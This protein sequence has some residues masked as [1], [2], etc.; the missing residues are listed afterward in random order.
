MGVWVVGAD[1]RVQI[2]GWRLAGASWAGG[3]VGL[4]GWMGGLVNLWTSKQ[5]HA[6]E[7]ARGGQLLVLKSLL[8]CMTR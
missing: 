5:G 1:W 8:S 3:W 6:R 7:L 2:G 4:G